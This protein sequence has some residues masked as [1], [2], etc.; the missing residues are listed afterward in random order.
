MSESDQKPPQRLRSEIWFNDRA[1]PGETAIYIERFGNYGITRKE[2]QSARPV[3]G[4]AQSGGDLTPCNRIHMTLVARVKDGIRDA[5]GIAFEF[6]MH[7]IQ[8]SCRRPTAALDRN[9]A[10]LGLVE[11]FCG[12]PLDGVV[13]MTGCDKTTPACLMA[14]AT[15]N[16]PAI[17]LSGGPMLDGYYDGKLAGSGMALWEARRLHAEGKIDYPELIDMVAASTP[18]AGHCNTMGTALS[19]NSLAEALG[20]SLPGCAAIPAPY[21]ERAK[22]AYATGLRI[23]DMVREDLTPSRI[24]TREAFENSIVVNSAIGGSTNCP[25]HIVAIARHIGV[26]LET[27][28]WETIGHDIP[29]LAN[30]QP[31]GEFLGEGYHRAGGV[32]AIFGELIRAGKIHT[33]ALTVTG[34]T[35]GENYQGAKTLDVN[36]IRPFDK[37][38]MEKAGFL[39]VSG[40][41]FESALMKTSVISQDFRRRFLSTPGSEDCFTARAIVFEGPEDYRANIND[42][43][44]QIDEHCILVVRGCGPIGYPGSAEVVNMTPP[45]HLVREGV[46]MLPCLGDGRQSGTSDSPSILNASPESAAGGNL[47]ILQTGDQVKVDLKSRRVDVLLSD[48]EIARRRQ[49]L[50]PPPITNNSPWQELYRANVGQLS[51]G[52]C[53]DF[54]VQYRDLRKVVPRHSH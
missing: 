47:A 54:A 36:I 15:V 51:T 18:S 17:A 4:I 28:D 20:M 14:A 31:A 12:Y 5:G 35:I 37:P 26:P 53:L 23:V 6:P 43:A 9:L 32:P 7:P 45:D 3:I 41:L 2:L 16:L 48:E 22:I 19:M 42:P 8:E 50:K 38:L 52:A 24:L 25:P 39:V 13:L 10:Y 1:E 11:I 40:N 29:L 33:G 27:Q 30:I 21:G 46:R 34:K 44:L 49:N